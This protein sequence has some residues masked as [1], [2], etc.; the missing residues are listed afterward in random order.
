MRT[1]VIDI[2]IKD[3][4]TKILNTLFR[5]PHRKE[6]HLIHSSKDM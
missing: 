4:G 3:D 1:H 6:T 2:V 5:A